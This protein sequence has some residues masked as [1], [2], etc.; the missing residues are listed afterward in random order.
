MTHFFDSDLLNEFEAVDAE[1]SPEAQQSDYSMI[2]RI[3][4]DGGE[5]S[6]SCDGANLSIREEDE[7]EEIHSC[8][9]LVVATLA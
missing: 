6:D 2:S 8:G 4:D 3:S 9:K 7:A 1:Y 5:E